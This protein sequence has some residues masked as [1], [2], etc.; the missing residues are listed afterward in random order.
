MLASPAHSP[1]LTSTRPHADQDTKKQRTKSRGR[2]QTGGGYSRV[3]PSPRRLA[4]AGCGMSMSSPGGWPRIFISTKT[5]FDVCPPVVPLWGVQTWRAAGAQRR[6][7]SPWRWRRGRSRGSR[8]SRSGSCHT[9]GRLVAG[10]RGT[11]SAASITWR[12]ALP[13]SVD[14]PAAPGRRKIPH[15]RHGPVSRSHA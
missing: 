8:C 7:T 14:L 1:A 11:T 6:C 4:T 5:H 2:C 12:W 3:L 15:A 9:I 10:E 13:L